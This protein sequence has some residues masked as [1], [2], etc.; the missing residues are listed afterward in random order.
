ML[1]FTFITCILLPLFKVFIPIVNR[2]FAHPWHPVQFKV[3]DFPTEYFICF[4]FSSE[5]VCCGSPQPQREFP[6]QPFNPD[7]GNGFQPVSTHSA[8]PIQSPPDYSSIENCHSAQPILPVSP[9][10]M[11]M[12]LQPQ[13]VNSQND[14]SPSNQPAPG[15]V[16]SNHSNLVNSSALPSSAFRS[17]TNPPSNL[18]TTHRAWHTNNLTA[19][20]NVINFASNDF[21]LAINEL[22]SA[23]NNLSLVP[24]DLSLAL[25]EFHHASKRTII[26]RLSP[27]QVLLPFTGYSIYLRFLSWSR[28]IL[29]VSPI[30]VLHSPFIQ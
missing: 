7:L 20:P 21:C 27:V 8:N 12:S 25:I 6:V 30:E 2:A 29:G 11:Q 5:V 14:H 28:P 26:I 13:Q 9:K 15:S 10:Q 22:Y 17:I 1:I 24:N 19:K 4:P 3:V 23:P 18:P 16:N